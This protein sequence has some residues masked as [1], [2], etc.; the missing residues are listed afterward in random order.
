MATGRNGAKKAW[1][2]EENKKGCGRPRRQYKDCIK[3]LK[4]TGTPRPMKPC[5]GQEGVVKNR[6]HLQPNVNG[7][8]S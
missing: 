1:E 2:E 5:H 7:K 6:G 3:R 8:R 4:R